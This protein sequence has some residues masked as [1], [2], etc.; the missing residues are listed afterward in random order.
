MRTTARH[1]TSDFLS[2]QSV[3]SPSRRPRLLQTFPLN[4][5]TLTDP[6]VHLAPLVDPYAR[7]EVEREDAGDRGD[8]AG[9]NDDEDDCRVPVEVV[10]LGERGELGGGVLSR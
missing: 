7:D 6:H 5:V 3:D 1:R 9:D 10:W 8:Q 2:P 4:Q